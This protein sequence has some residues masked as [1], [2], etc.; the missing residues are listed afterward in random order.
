[1]TER[2]RRVC[3]RLPD[4]R[5][6]FVTATVTVRWRSRIS[7]K[8]LMRGTARLSSLRATRPVAHRVLPRLSMKLLRTAAAALLGLTAA[9]AAAP[10]TRPDDMSGAE[11]RDA[12]RSHRRAASAHARKYDPNARAH[13]PASYGLPTVRAI[14]GDG[15]LGSDATV[16]YG[17]RQYNPTNEHREQA[18][19][20]REHMRQHSGAAAAL[21]ASTDSACHALPATVRT[22]CPLVAG[23]AA[24][25]A[26]TDGVRVRLVAPASVESFV[27]RARCHHAFARERHFRSMTACALYLP[28]VEVRPGRDGASVLIQSSD[29]AIAA[30]IRE[31]ILTPA[32]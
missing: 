12:A 30:A 4:L 18:E 15:P 25:E 9:C 23:V 28:T 17:E 22:E 16:A 26:I 2:T 29:P 1:M 10:G 31:R 20:H 7:R 24:V 27:A 11:H 3:T 14:N 32:E 21:E 5:T 6:H 8:R 19:L 13:Q